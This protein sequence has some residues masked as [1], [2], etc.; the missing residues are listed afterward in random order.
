MTF[1]RVCTILAARRCHDSGTTVKQLA[2]QAHRHPS[3]IR[4]WLKLTEHV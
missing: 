1:D 2:A 4:R 3:T